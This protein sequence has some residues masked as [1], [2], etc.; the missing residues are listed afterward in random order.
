MRESFSH[1]EE[2]PVSAHLD[3]SFA[4]VIMIPDPESLPNFWPLRSLT[5]VPVILLHI[6]GATS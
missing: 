4:D 2:G 3:F 5:F 1:R 6:P